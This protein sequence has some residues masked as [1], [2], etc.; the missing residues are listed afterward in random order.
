[1]RVVASKLAMVGSIWWV[2]LDPRQR[3]V[4]HDKTLIKHISLEKEGFGPGRR[5]VRPGR[6]FALVGRG[7]SLWQYLLRLAGV[8]CL[9]ILI[10]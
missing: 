7:M 3:L 4:T 10:T 1:M 6:Q 9:D 2:F 8:D 5:V